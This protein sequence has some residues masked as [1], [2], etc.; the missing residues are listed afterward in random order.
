MGFSSIKIGWPLLQP[1]KHQ[2][3]ESWK[4]RFNRNLEIDVSLWQDECK[5]IFHWLY[6]MMKFIYY[7][8]II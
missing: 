1:I 3:V 2:K 7:G 6:E 4:K 8:L 5:V